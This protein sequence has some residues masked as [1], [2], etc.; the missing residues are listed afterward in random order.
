MVTEKSEGLLTNEMRISKSSPTCGSGN[1]V[2]VSSDDAER[3][4]DNPP[5]VAHDSLGFGVLKF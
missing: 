5:D 2:K 1:S 4:E 3:I